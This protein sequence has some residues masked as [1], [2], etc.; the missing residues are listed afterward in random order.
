MTHEELRDKMKKAMGGRVHP[1]AR[2]TWAEFIRSKGETFFLNWEWVKDIRIERW[3]EQ[4][5]DMEA[6]CSGHGLTLEIYRPHV[7][8]NG[9]PLGGLKG[10]LLED[11]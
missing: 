8:K 3:A 2:E 5:P 10:T 6:Y 9:R 1:E 4:H 11:K 7:D